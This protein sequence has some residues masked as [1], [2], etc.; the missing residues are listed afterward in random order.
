MKDEEKP[1]RNQNS[2]KFTRGVRI[3]Y[4]LYQIL[5]LLEHKEEKYIH[6]NLGKLYFSWYL[7]D[8]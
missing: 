8:R 1:V 3:S 5:V 2:Q 7:K 6:W 4:N